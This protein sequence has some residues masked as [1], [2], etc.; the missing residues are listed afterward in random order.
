MF[1]LINYISLPLHLELTKKYL[2]FGEKTKPLPNILS[3]DRE[4]I[5]MRLV[6]NKKTVERIMA[7]HIMQRKQSTVKVNTI[8]AKVFFK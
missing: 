6:V 2:V 1:A 4:R 5:M 3:L 7:M 8:S